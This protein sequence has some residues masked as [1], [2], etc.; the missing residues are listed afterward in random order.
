MKRFKAIIH[1]MR[2]FAQVAFLAGVCT[3][4]S[5]AAAAGQQSIN[6]IGL[7]GKTVAIALADLPRKSIDT[8][9]AAG[10]KTT[11]E[12]VLLRDVL[13]RAG[14]P[15]GEALR[16]KALA[17]VVIATAR[18][19]YQVAYS[20]A[21]VDA[22]FNDFVMLIADTRNG[23]PLLPDTG[24]LQIIVSQDKRAARWIR[25]LTTLEVRQLQ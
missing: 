6:V 8:A 13:E 2:R 1:S 9:D 22:G 5:V 15:M 7:D 12:G 11:H 25:Q 21:E 20:I 19:G 16:G 24:P 10:I 18:D 17:R 3:V 23:K 4:S 14:V